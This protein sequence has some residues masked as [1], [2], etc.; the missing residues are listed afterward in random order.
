MQLV[1][2]SPG[3]FIIEEGDHGNE[4]FFLG[5]GTVAVLAG[6][7][8]V[9]TLNDGACFGEIALLVPGA[10]RTAS[11]MAVVF[12]EAYALARHDFASCLAGC[13]SSL[14]LDS[15]QPLAGGLWHSSG[16]PRPDPALY[17]R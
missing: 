10:L 1:V 8:Q 13:V 3:D 5:I 14:R 15:P 2:F 17:L 7:R 16:H 9:A 6:G 11:I 4:V 12:S